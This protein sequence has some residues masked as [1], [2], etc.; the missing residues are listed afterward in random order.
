LKIGGIGPR[1][2]GPSPRWSVHETSLNG[3]RPSGDLRLGFKWNKKLFLFWS[4]SSI[5]DPMAQDVPSSSARPDRI[6]PPG[7]HG[8]LLRRPKLELWC[9][10]CDEVSSYVIYMTRGT[11][12]AHLRWRKR[13]RESRR[14]RRDL[15]DSWWRW[16]AP[17]MVHWWQEQDEHTPHIPLSRLC[18]SNSSGGDELNSHDKKSLVARVWCCGQIFDE[19]GPLFVGVLGPT[20][21]GDG[22]LHFL[23]I[24]QTLIRLR[25]KDFWKEMN[26]GL[27]TVWKPN[28]QPG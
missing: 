11:R 9:T 10:I 4:W 13:T 21:G 2:G 17:P 6:E 7:R 14:R 27:V 8:H 25:F 19:Y 1:C 12:F 23:S 5:Q 28:F 20:C 26:F 24:N 18:A 15:D 16:L 22:D 3:G